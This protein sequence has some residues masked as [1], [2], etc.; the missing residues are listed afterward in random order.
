MDFIRTTPSQPGF[1]KRSKQLHSSARKRK[2]PIACVDEQ[3]YVS[4]TTAE[5]LLLLLLVLF[6]LPLRLALLLLLRQVYSFFLFDED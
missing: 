3:S 1:G 2:K 6:L 5:P 4:P